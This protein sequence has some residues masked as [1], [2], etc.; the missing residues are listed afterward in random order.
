[1]VETLIRHIVMALIIW[2][3]VCCYQH[4]VLAQASL[5]RLG[6]QRVRQ[7]AAQASQSVP[8]L[9]QQTRVCAV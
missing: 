5:E 7:G 3:V 1:M 4:W 6:R 9:G 2:Q 8:S